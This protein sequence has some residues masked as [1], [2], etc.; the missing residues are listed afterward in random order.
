MS[1][2]AILLALPFRGLADLQFRLFTRQ[3]PLEHW[4][5]VVGQQL[6]WTAALVLLG[7]W[8]MARAARRVVVQ[9]G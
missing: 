9:G 8:V 6:A 2:Q 3:L 1:P 4:P 5:A 7:R